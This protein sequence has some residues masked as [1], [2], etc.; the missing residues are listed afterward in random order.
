MF[1]RAIVCQ[2]VLFQL[3]GL[4]EDPLGQREIF[5]PFLVLRV[6]SSHDIVELWLTDNALVDDGPTDGLLPVDQRLDVGAL[7]DFGECFGEHGPCDA[8]D[9][10][11]DAEH[12]R[13]FFN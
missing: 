12:K 1:E 9:V 6:E 11:L 10:V 13:Y 5:F 2:H 4:Q 3:V 8:C 7:F